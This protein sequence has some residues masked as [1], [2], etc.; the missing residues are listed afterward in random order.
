MNSIASFKFDRDCFDSFYAAWVAH[1]S[2]WR[3]FA[4]PLAILLLAVS[5][6]ALFLLPSYRPLAAAL[7]VVAMGRVNVSEIERAVQF[8]TGFTFSARGPLGPC[9]NSYSTF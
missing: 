2:R 5:S 1:R 7:A 4:M 6:I 9:P 3:R 8:S